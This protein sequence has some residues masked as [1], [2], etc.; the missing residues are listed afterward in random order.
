MHRLDADI[1]ASANAVLDD[2]LLLPEVGE[3]LG[4]EA[5][6]DI[7]GTT[8]GEGDNEF[9]RLG[10]EAGLCLRC[11]SKQQATQH[12]EFGESGQDAPA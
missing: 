10:R 3:F 9:H 1:A 12:A 6:A 2:D 8:G 4:H 5:G 11:G 7:G